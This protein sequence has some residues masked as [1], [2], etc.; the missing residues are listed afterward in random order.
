MKVRRLG[1]PRSFSS[2]VTV[3]TKQTRRADKLLYVD[4][5]KTTSESHALSFSSSASR[6]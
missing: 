4:M 2:K 6:T 3:Q 5:T 1:G